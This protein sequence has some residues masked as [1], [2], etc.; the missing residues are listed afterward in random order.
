[1]PTPTEDTLQRLRTGD[2]FEGETFSDL[3]LQ[4]VSLVDKE[5]YRCTFENCRLQETR[6]TDSRLEACV[7]RGCDLTR[8]QL[9]GTGLRGVRFEG[10]KLMGVDFSAVSPNPEVSFE[11]CNLRYASF[12]GLG[13]RKTPFLRCTAQEA[14][15]LDADLT[16]AD[17]TG[18]DL[19]G[20]NIRG[21]TLAKTDLRGATGA[22][23]DPA[24]N[25]ARGA[26]VSLEAAVLLA[27]SLG[28]VVAGHGDEAVGRGGRRKGRS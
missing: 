16:E 6:W 24:R 15:L 7:F 27:Q 8:A 21:C 28:L 1:M 14:N 20:A 2:A 23:V 3:D 5:L 10:S 26:L 9:G 22:F 25:R 12:V 13:L 19:T 17:F 18:S 11:A 4:G